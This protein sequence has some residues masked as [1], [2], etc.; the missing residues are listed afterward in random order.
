MEKRT[1]IG[2]GLALIFIVSIVIGFMYKDTLFTNQAIITYPD[3]CVETY[4]NAVLIGEKCDRSNVSEVSRYNQYGDVL[5]F[6]LT[7]EE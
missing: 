4:E 2:I 7:M 3:G 6:N 5:N 1:M